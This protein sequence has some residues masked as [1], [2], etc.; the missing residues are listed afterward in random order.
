MKALVYHGPSQKSW[1]TV[2][3]GDVVVV[4]GTGPFMRVNAAR[5]ARSEGVMPAMS[6]LAS[7]N[8][9]PSYRAGPSSR[10]D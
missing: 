5:H 9:P 4:V 10:V 8:R 6:G 1:D 7:G 3:P 2:P